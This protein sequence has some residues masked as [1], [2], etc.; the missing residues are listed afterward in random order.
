[1]EYFNRKI[2]ATGK[3][4]G[5]NE[6]S[7]ESLKS[8]FQNYQPLWRDFSYN[9][10]LKQDSLMPKRY[11]S[12]IYFGRFKDGKKEGLGIMIYSANKRFEGLF[13][14]DLRTYGMEQDGEVYYVGKF[15][16]GAKE[17]EGGFWRSPD[18][19]LFGRF[20]A[21]EWVG[22]GFRLETKELICTDNNSI[23][24]VKSIDNYVYV[25]KYTGKCKEEI[26]LEQFPDGDIYL[27]S[28]DDNKSEGYGEYFWANGAVYQGDFMYG[29]RHG[30][31]FWFI[32]G[33]DQFVGEYSNDKKC[34]SG[35]Y[36]W[37]N[38]T[39]YQG[40]FENDYRHG[41]GEMHWAD[42]RS[43]KG[44]WLNGLEASKKLT[45][46]NTTS[47]EESFRD[48]YRT[49]LPSVKGR[50]D[51]VTPTKGKGDRSADF[52]Q[53]SR[54]IDVKRSLH[55]QQ[56]SQRMIRKDRLGAIFNPNYAPDF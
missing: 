53:S 44:E 6:A 4:E 8:Y 11:K 14:S 23:S 2:R 47:K 39:V 54:T 35:E 12:G 9:T 37:K 17:G 19:A 48:G 7:E 33:G 32:E 56:G 55:Q 40:M 41:F 46:L 27:G 18:L 29:M 30:R 22:E 16:K 26:G 43:Y 38:G 3:E 1:M 50:Y 10:L 13:E 51:T 31:G 20:V 49:G 36:K 21:D 5:V 34:G 45:F 42:G 28:Y 25:G 15:S 24:V 52:K